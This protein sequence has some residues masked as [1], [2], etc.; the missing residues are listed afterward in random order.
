MICFPPGRA[1]SGLLHREK[2]DRAVELNRPRQD[3]RHKGAVP[4]DGRPSDEGNGRTWM[5]STGSCVLARA[6]TGWVA[7]GR[8][9]S[10]EAF[11]KQN[12]GGVDMGSWRAGGV[13]GGCG[14]KRRREGLAGMEGGG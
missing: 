8:A 3:S 7:G 11:S 4:R 9:G 5:V 6:G 2:R 13:A 1:G 14:E 10:R 12:V